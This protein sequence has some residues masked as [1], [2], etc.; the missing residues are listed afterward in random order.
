MIEAETHVRKD[1]FAKMPHGLR[2]GLADFGRM[3]LNGRERSVI[4]IVLRQTDGWDKPTARISD[5]FLARKT[6]IDASNCRNIVAG[7]TRRGILYRKG[8]RLGLQKDPALWEPKNRVENEAVSCGENVDKTASKTKREPLQKQSEN[9][10]KNDAHSKDIINRTI[11]KES[12]PKRDDEP[13]HI[14][15]LLPSAF[16]PINK[17]FAPSTVT[18]KCLS[19]EEIERELHDFI[20][21]L[22]R[23]AGRV[24]FKWPQTTQPLCAE[25]A[26]WGAP[27]TRDEF[28]RAKQILIGQYRNGKAG[29]LKAERF[30]PAYDLKDTLINL[31]RNSG[32]ARTG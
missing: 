23:Q 21:P 19:A 14:R 25:M 4:D 7:L 13:Q 15:A 22:L 31:V 3:R 5:S 28:E 2:E 1:G 29:R 11:G 30:S 16:S 24:R 26:G 8:R 6:G 18:R 12:I 20:D 27:L 17:D 9:C 10:F 32:R